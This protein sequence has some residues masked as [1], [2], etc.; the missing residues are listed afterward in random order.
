MAKDYYIV[1]FEKT[2]EEGIRTWYSFKNKKDFDEWYEDNEDIQKIEKIVAKGVDWEYAIKLCEQVSLS[3]LQASAVKQST[4][5]NGE[6]DP[7]I[8][9]LEFAK[10]A[11]FLKNR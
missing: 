4:D 5:E 9:E 7:F 1:V 8:L 11:F 3:C 10:V 2:E 6:I